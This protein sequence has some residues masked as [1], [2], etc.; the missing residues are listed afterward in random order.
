MIAEGTVDI[1]RHLDLFLV[2]AADEESR[3]DASQDFLQR[4]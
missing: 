2:L 4:Q 1:F 3:V